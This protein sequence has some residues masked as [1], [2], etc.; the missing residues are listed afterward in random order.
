[1][2]RK[3]QYNYGDFD[4]TGTSGRPGSVAEHVSRSHWYQLTCLIVYIVLQADPGPLQ[5][6]AILTEVCN[7]HNC[8]LDRH[9]HIMSNQLIAGGTGGNGV[10]NRL[11][12]NQNSFQALPDTPA[13]GRIA[14]GGRGNQSQGDSSHAT[15]SPAGQQGSAD[16]QQGR[17]D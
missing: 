3:G 11:G 14:F 4:N 6:L 16:K 1:M 15:H 2:V 12:N 7:V 5:D 13:P 10:F 17:Y 9:L 8:L